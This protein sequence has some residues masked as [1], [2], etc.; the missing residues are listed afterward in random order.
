MSPRAI[1]LN[2]G[3][4]RSRS[5]YAEGMDSRGNIFNIFVPY[6]IRSDQWFQKLKLFSHINLWPHKTLVN[7]IKVIWKF[8]KEALFVQYDTIK[9]NS[10]MPPWCQ[11]MYSFHAFIHVLRK[12][13]VLIHGNV[14][15]ATL[16]MVILRFK[17]LTLIST[18]VLWYMLT[19]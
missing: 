6:L 3:N 19:P 15:H 7:F 14:L 10:H 16:K 8:C 5:D 13:I 9:I 18:T 1:I 4:Q 11:N 17:P 12:A 2:V